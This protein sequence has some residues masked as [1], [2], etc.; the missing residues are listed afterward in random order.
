LNQ[1]SDNAG[2]LFSPHS[3]TNGTDSMTE[4]L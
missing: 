1:N 2:K 3:L 4:S